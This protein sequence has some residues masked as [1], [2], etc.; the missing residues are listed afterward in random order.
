VW[1]KL[2]T[3]DDGDRVAMTSVTDGCEQEYLVKF[4]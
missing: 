2:W 4:V 1:E 3:F